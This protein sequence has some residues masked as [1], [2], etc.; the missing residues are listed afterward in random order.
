MGFTAEEEALLDA[1][2]PV[3]DT[4]TPAQA[5]IALP[6]GLQEA[7]NALVEAIY[8]AVE[9]AGT[10][11]LDFSAFQPI[12]QPDASGNY[13]EGLGPWGRLMCPE[14]LAIQASEY[15]LDYDSEEAADDLDMF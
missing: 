4:V 8:A 13:P 7:E 12:V 14:D 6:D 3:T 11:D 15:V 2:F 1:A 10:A 5:A 9:A